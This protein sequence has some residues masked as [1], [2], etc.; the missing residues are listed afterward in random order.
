MLASSSPSCLQPWPS[1]KLLHFLSNPNPKTKSP[2]SFPC[3]NPRVNC[4][5][6]LGFED[7]AA[8]AHNKVLVAAGL[9]GAIGQLSK[10][11]TSVVL[12][13]RPFSFKASTVVATA[14]SLGLDRGLSDSVF[15]LAAVYAVLVMYDAQGVRRE[16]G[17]H[18]K[19]INKFVHGRQTIS[20][21]KD[22]EPTGSQLALKVQNISSHVSEESNGREEEKIVS[23]VALGS[24]VRSSV[25][26]LT[27]TLSESVGHTELEVIAGAMLGFFV[28]LVVYYEI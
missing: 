8:I 23:S 27:Y 11:F 20:A 25:S 5:L 10:P 21:S 12:Y 3:P 26:D 16:V 15:G 4:A 18:A 28:G 2:H 14:L 13:K 9:S 17:K 24:T 7:V 1:K 6:G 22:D 19:M